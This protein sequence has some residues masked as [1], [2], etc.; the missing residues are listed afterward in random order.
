M[1]DAREQRL[2]AAE[3]L[4]GRMARWLDDDVLDDTAA[5][6]LAELRTDLTAEERGVREQAL[7]LLTDGWKE[8]QAFPIGPWVRG[9]T[10]KTD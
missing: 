5:T 10:D 7:E 9:D 4:L 8:R 1:T 2:A 6:I 3:Y